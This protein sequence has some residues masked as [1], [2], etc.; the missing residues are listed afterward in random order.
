MRARGRFCVLACALMALLPASAA[1][2][3]IAPLPKPPAI[4]AKPG[5]V[6][7]TALIAPVSRPRAHTTIAPARRHAVR[8]ASTTT[9]RTARAPRRGFVPAS[10]HGGRERAWRVVSVGGREA[11]V[12]PPIAPTP[13]QLVGAGEVLAATSV[14]WPAWKIA[15]LVLL[16]LAE[17][18]VLAALIRRA[19]FARALELV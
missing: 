18:A 12:V 9:H 8:S 3:K 15:L 2:A 6:R 16:A 17:T 19:R 4:A 10:S 11:P 13:L 14:A 1:H 7:G 5:A